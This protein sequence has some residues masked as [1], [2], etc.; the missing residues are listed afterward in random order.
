VPRYDVVVAGLGAMGAATTLALARNGVRV[1]G[2]DAHRP[3]HELG[4]SHGG[5]RITRR[6]VAEGDVYVPL[7]ARSQERWRELE[8]E[9][10]EELFVQCGV[11][12][13][14]DAA[15]GS[16]HGRVDFARE[17]KALA[18][19]HGIDHEMLT[20]DDVRGRFPALAAPNGDA[21]FE[22]QGGYLRTEA[23][24]TA[25]LAAAERRGAVLHYDEVVTSWSA[26]ASGYRIVTTNGAYDAGRVV[27]A[28]GPWIAELVPELRRTCSVQRQVAHWL[29]IEDAPAYERLAALPVYLWF[30]GPG[31]ED[32]FY[33]FPAVDG[34][35]GGVKVATERYGAP[36]T[37]ASVVRS[38]LGSEPREVFDHHVA[39]RLSGVTPAALRSSVCLYT[40]TPDFGFVLDAL[41]ADPGVLVVS[42]CSGHGF[43]HAPAIGECAAALAVGEPAPYDIGAFSL[44]RFA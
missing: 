18:D 43:K 20:G 29:A 24:I 13:L 34:P 27:L 37:P 22:P 5:T 31:D 15:G 17:T 4:S 40:V 32:W 10:R 21:Y 42:A 41:P 7:V 1:A 6:S 23:C 26:N 8:A 2:F 36:T 16:H 19:L 12:V 30:H 38:V 25:M 39:G 35:H 3:P 44:S 9:L 28:A 14:G 33:G 11:L